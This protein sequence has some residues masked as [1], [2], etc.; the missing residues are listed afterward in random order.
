MFDLNRHYNRQE[1]Q[2][3][4]QTWTFQ[5]LIPTGDLSKIGVVTNRLV[6]MALKAAEVG[7]LLTSPLIYLK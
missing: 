6:G 4:D 1:N 7:Y 3:P 5:C 2:P